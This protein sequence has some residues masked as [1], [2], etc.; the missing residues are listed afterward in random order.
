MTAPNIKWLD[1][2]A[3]LLDNRFRIPFTN[4]RF[5]VDAVIGLIPY[6]GDVLSFAVSGILVLYMARHGGSGMLALKMVGN[7]LLDGVVGTVP[8]LGDLFDLR[9]RANLRNVH[10]LKQH[11]EMGMHQGS[12]WW[13][14]FLILGAMV[15]SLAL[16]LWLV[17]KVF[18]WIF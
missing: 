16:S 15:L 12:A 7:I 13:V 4:I 5:G 8:L 10:L 6:A 18:Q 3:D 1:A 2:I 11:Y 9:Y 14:L 17:G